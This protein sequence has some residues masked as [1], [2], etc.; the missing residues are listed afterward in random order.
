MTF[1]VA[2]KHLEVVL[3]ETI[4]DERMYKA[5]LLRIV[6]KMKTDKKAFEECVQAVTN[7]LRLD[8]ED[9]RRYVNTH[10]GEVV[11]SVKSKGGRVYWE[12]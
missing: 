12:I 7:E 11:A 4:K 6:M 8:P 10:M 9:F 5:G 2:P 1:I 3:L